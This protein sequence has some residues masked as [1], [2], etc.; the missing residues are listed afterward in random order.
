VSSLKARNLLTH[1]GAFFIFIILCSLG[2]W[3]LYRLQ[4]KQQLIRTIKTQAAQDPIL[5]EDLDFTQPLATYDFRRVQIK[6]QYKG[7]SPL[8]LG[9]RTYKGKAGQHA[10]HP[11]QAKDGRIILIDRGW[12]PETYGQQ[13][14]LSTLPSGPLLLIGML[15]CSST[16]TWFTPV[17]QPGKNQ[18]YSVK[19]AEMAYHLSLP[20]QPCYV[21]LEEKDTPAPFPYPNRSYRRLPNRHLEYALTWYAFALIFGIIYGLILW[22][23]RHAQG[24]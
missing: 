9:P 7:S 22:R 11:F 20:L 12:A 18:W 5:F 3:Q 4:W 19:I 10:L 17:N 13:A 1:L 15:R 14:L 6:G 16:E 24:N 23:G 2:T 8:L 21:A